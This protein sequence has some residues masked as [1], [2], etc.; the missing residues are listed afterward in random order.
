MQPTPRTRE[1]AATSLRVVAA[2]ALLATGGIH[3]EQYL[4]DDFSV[5]PTIGPLFLLNF[6]AG[7]ALGLYFLIPPRPPKGRTRRT[8][9]LVAAWI[10]GAVAGGA[11]VALF[12]SERT[13]LFG[14]ME[15]GHRLEIVIAIA[16]EATAVLAL[17]AMVALRRPRPVS[18]L[19]APSNYTA[20]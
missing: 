2:I 16:A 6:A 7:T 19:A 15:R 5:L 12:V 4:F 18:T 20:S 13:P 17:S 8:L 10:G 11:L 1:R 9:D 3:L 14:F